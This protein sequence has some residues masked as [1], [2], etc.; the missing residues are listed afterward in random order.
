MRRAPADI[1]RIEDALINLEGSALLLQM[2]VT[3][4]HDLDSDRARQTATWHANRQLAA[5]VTELRRVYNSVH[6]AVR[7]GGGV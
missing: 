4:G 3:F 1:D 5:D 2:V 6:G 7:K